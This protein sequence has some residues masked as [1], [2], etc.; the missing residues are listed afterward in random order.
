MKAFEVEVETLPEAVRLLN[1]LA[2]YDIFQFENKVKPD[3]C[4]AGG[5]VMF[6]KESGEWVDWYDEETGMDDPEQFVREY[7]E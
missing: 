1:T 6:E 5:V 4:N 7:L 2:K 3:Y